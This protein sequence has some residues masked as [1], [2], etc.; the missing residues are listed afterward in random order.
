M[1]PYQWNVG[2]NLGSNRLQILFG[3]P[4]RKA[5]RG[6][7]TL[8]GSCI[9]VCDTSCSHKTASTLHCL[10]KLFQNCVVLEKKGV[11]EKWVVVGASIIA[12]LGDMLFAFSPQTLSKDLA[13]ECSFRV[14]WLCHKDTTLDSFESIWYSGQKHEPSNETIVG[15]VEHQCWSMIEPL[16]IWLL[17]W[18]QWSWLCHWL[19]E[20]MIQACKDLCRPRKICD[21]WQHSLQA[22]LSRRKQLEA[23][24]INW[25][26][27][28][29]DGEDKGK[30]ANKSAF[31]IQSE[32]YS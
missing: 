5:S 28:L 21:T 4:N 25:H 11:T 1:L 7:P 32:S 3:L 31:F 24:G 8:I 14:R 16:E 12:L 30:G 18:Q 6:S 9:I 2:M 27:A 15:N 13:W 23:H 26:A 29:G 17:L 20:D 19:I 10:S 22:P